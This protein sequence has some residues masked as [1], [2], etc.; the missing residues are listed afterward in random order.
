MVITYNKLTAPLIR[1]FRKIVGE[2]SCFESF[3]IRWSYSFGGTI[4]EKEWIPDLILLPN[5]DEQISKIVKLA[6]A[7]NRIILTR[8]IGM[9]KIRHVTHGYWIRS[10]NPEEQILEV[11]K[12]LDLF[13]QL[14][15]FS[16][17]KKCNGKIDKIIGIPN[18]I[19]M[20]K[21]SYERF[22]KKDV[23]P[24]ERKE[25]G[26]QGAFKSVFPIRDF[27]GTSSLEFV[28]YTF[29][30]VKYSEEE[31]LNKGMTYEAPLRLTVRLLVFDTDGAEGTKS[32][33]DIKEQEIYF[34]PSP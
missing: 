28:K 9:L 23:P 27:S 11:L 13:S 30:D 25:V 33:R 6:N 3:V 5:T 12:R 17:C 8:D 10:L 7:E 18:L 14:D 32:I 1:K 16:R 29:E 22:L 24:E 20:Q 21:K 19:E 4:F 2:N 15:P 26:L 31:C 34:E